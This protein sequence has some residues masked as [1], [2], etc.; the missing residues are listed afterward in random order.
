MSTKPKIALC[1]SGGG[2]RA[3]AYHLGCLKALHEHNILNNVSIISSISGGSLMLGLYAYSEEA[4]PAFEQK[5]K[6]LLKDGLVKKALKNYFFRF[7]PLVTIPIYLSLVLVAS[8]RKLFGLGHESFPRLISRTN[9]LINAIESVVGDKLVSSKTR[10]NLE[11]VINST[12][13]DDGVAFRVGNCAV[14]SWKLN[15]KYGAIK[16]DFKLAEAIGASAAYPLFL[17]SYVRKVNFES[18]NSEWV[19]LSDGGVYENLGIT[20]FFKKKEANIGFYHVNP[21]YVIACDAE[22]ESFNGKSSHLI[23]GRLANCFATTMNRVRSFNFRVLNDLKAQG[24][25]KGFVLSTLSMS[26]SSL[27][28]DLFNSVNRDEVIFYPTN[29]SAMSED[30][31]KKLSDRGYQVTSRLIREYVPE[32]IGME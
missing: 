24:E 30:S 8:L 6:D 18:G 15:Q 2:S 19:T 17:P 13:L 10:R 5:V 16:N 29:F 32:L 25:I 31:I 11:V 22:N 27:P 9:S 14:T 21:D 20:P 1:L 4:F 28:N 7:Y 3:V 23:I 12:N 26:D